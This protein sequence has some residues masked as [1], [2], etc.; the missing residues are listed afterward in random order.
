MKGKDSYATRPRPLNYYTLL[1]SSNIWKSCTNPVKFN[2][3]TCQMFKSLLWILSLWLWKLGCGSN[4]QCVFMVH[5]FPYQRQKEK[6]DLHYQWGGGGEVHPSCTHRT[7]GAPIVPHPAPFVRVCHKP[8]RARRISLSM[9]MYQDVMCTIPP[10][11]N[12]IFLLRSGFISSDIVRRREWYLDHFDSMNISNFAGFLRPRVV[13][14]G[15]I[16]LPYG[17]FVEARW[18]VATKERRQFT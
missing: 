3:E 5:A 15:R 8:F 11:K 12:G 18:S 16:N 2:D 9:F 10:R 6:K 4:A 17:A 1:C 14:C 13:N 7:A